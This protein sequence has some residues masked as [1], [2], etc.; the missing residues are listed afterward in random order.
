MRNAG[1]CLIVVAV[2]LTGSAR[3]V[4]DDAR[5]PRHLIYLQGRPGGRERAAAGPA[6]RVLRA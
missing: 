4:T 5:R 1:V 6:V 2:L 3:G